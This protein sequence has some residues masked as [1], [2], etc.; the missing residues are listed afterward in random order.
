MVDSRKHSE[1][2][3]DPRPPPPRWRSGTS[4]TVMEACP[5]H[6]RKGGGR[7]GEALD[8]LWGICRRGDPEVSLSVTHSFHHV[9]ASFV[10]ERDDPGTHREVG[11]GERR[12]AWPRLEPRL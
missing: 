3:T 11:R 4:A 7:G 12:E 6:T 10:S 1:K 5:G 2:T 9:S 8:S